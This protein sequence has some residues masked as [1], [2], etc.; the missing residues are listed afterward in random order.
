MLF[1]CFCFVYA[2]IGLTCAP[3][4]FPSIFLT[5]FR[6][7]IG[8]RGRLLQLFVHSIYNY[9]IYRFW[10]SRF[11][12]LGFFFIRRCADQVS[13]LFTIQFVISC[14]LPCWVSFVLPFGSARSP[15]SNHVCSDRPKTAPA[16]QDCTKK[17]PHPP[18]W[19]LSRSFYDRFGACLVHKI[20]HAFLAV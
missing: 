3:G 2:F 1:L 18:G 4:S 19:C 11:S 6:P 7:K 20:A 5:R 16:P 9:F 15:P 8:G 14:F 13:E 12:F 17:L 10:Q